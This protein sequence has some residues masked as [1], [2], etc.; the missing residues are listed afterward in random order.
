MARATLVTKSGFVR[1]MTAGISEAGS[2]ALTGMSF[3]VPAGKRRVVVAVNRVLNDVP[4]I[5]IVVEL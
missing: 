1:T 4:K 3:N 2:R 5:F